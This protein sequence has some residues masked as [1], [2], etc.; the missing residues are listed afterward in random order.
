MW[1]GTFSQWGIL[2]L[3]P[4]HLADDCISVFPLPRIHLVWWPH[5][6]F[7]PGYWPISIL[8]NQYDWQIYTG[9]KNTGYCVWKAVRVI[10]SL[11]LLPGICKSLHLS[12]PCQ[13]SLS[14]FCLW[15]SYLVCSSIALWFWFVV[16]FGKTCSNLVHFCLIVELWVFLSNF[17]NIEPY[18]HKD[19]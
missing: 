10:A 13:H 14:R 3:L 9:Y 1:L 5:L 19:L 6:Y 4:L 11:C 17:L 15:S 7:L 18:L 12:P 8:W 2:I 16:F